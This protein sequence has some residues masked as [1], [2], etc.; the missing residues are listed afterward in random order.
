MMLQRQED[1]AIAEVR[2]RVTVSVQLLLALLHRIRYSVRLEPQILVRPLRRSL[3]LVGEKPR[4]VLPLVRQAADVP[5][6]RERS[7]AVYDEDLDMESMD[8]MS[9]IEQYGCCCQREVE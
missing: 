3:V 8:C 5:C 6:E 7:V 9:A 2:S 1:C 4:L